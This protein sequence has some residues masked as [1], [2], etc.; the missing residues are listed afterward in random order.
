MPFHTFYLLG[1]EIEY[2]K[3]IQYKGK[4]VILD[5]DFLSYISDSLSWIPVVYPD[6]LG[7]HKDGFGLDYYGITVINKN[8]ADVLYSIM[9]SWSHLFSQ[10]PQNLK[11]SS[12]WVIER[13]D[14]IQE[15]NLLSRDICTFNREELIAK[16]TTLAEFAV[17]VK[18]GN[19]FILHHGI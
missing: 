1:Q 6:I 11:L 5:D 18:T 19:F 15:R 4:S 9:I 14:Q 12:P 3:A 13:Y 8:G 16:L 7:E 17:Q 2:N 10:G